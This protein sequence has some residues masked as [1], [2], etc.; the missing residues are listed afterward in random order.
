MRKVLMP[1]VMVAVM[2]F[3]L[4]S[5]KS[6]QA[7]VQTQNTLQGEWNIIELDGLSLVPADH[8]PF[9]FVG[10]NISEKSIY[11]SAGCNNIMG[12][13]ESPKLGKIKFGRLGMTMMMCPDMK[14]EARVTKVLETVKSYKFISENQLA[15][16]GKGSKPIAILEKA[17]RKEDLAGLEGSWLLESI[18]G[19]DLN[20]DSA[21]PQ[22]DIELL[23]K[24]VSG[25]AGCNRI[26]GKFEVKE[27]VTRSISFPNMA[28]TRMFCNNM[29]LEA[30]VLEALSAVNSYYILPSGLYLMF[31][32][33]EGNELLKY[34]K[35]EDVLFMH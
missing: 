17:E 7:M 34:E 21:K 10:F 12:S 9:P 24:R 5:C 16:Y 6:S 20:M 18:K 31:Y 4:P 8:Q 22:L 23:E 19:E 13:Y 2:L 15:F 33:A 25:N 14:I 29:E 35:I 1:L 32:D 28:A 30:K 11:G 27:G 3:L 26:T